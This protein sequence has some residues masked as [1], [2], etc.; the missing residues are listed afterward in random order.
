M[1]DS[2]DFRAPLTTRNPGAPSMAPSAYPVKTNGGAPPSRPPVENGHV[3]DR[4]HAKSLLVKG[5]WHLS[6]IGVD[7]RQHAPSRPN[8][9]PSSGIHS[10]R[11]DPAKSHVAVRQHEASQTRS[12]PPARLP[13]SLAVSRELKQRC[14]SALLDVACLVAEWHAICCEMT[15]NRL[16]LSDLTPRSRQWNPHWRISRRCGH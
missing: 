12:K 5:I 16:P 8:S 10:Q 1:P 11:P 4:Q 15:L 6:R 9:L 14:A 13:E 3:D 2:K 7:E